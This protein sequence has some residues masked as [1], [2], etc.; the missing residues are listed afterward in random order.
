MPFSDAIPSDQA[1]GSPR[2][3]FLYEAILPTQPTNFKVCSL[4]SL[5]V[6]PPPHSSFLLS[7]PDNDSTMYELHEQID[8]LSS[9][10]DYVINVSLYL[11]LP[12]PSVVF[13]SAPLFMF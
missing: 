3:P 2:G 9:F 1:R 4:L 10:V 13:S 5:V 11:P 12:L 7:L 6:F 8:H